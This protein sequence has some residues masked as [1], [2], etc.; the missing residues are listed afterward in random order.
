[1]ARAARNV[2]IV[3]VT[4]DSFSIEWTRPLAGVVTGYQVWAS[5]A[6]THNGYLDS[7]VSGFLAFHT[8]LRPFGSSTR[9]FID[10]SS[11]SITFSGCYNASNGGPHCIESW[12]LY[13]ISIVPAFLDGV[14]PLSSVVVTTSDDIPAQVTNLALVRLSCLLWGRFIILE[15][16]HVHKPHT[17]LAASIPLILHRGFCSGGRRSDGCASFVAVCFICVAC[18]SHVPRRIS[19]STFSCDLGLIG[20]ELTF[21][22][23]VTDLRAYTWLGSLLIVR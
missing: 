9:T 17:S 14:G 18:W 15:H 7:N 11:T 13:Q 21:S 12:T 4:H 19:S 10:D 8:E 5:F 22:G 1:M 20:G 23:T 16:K 6:E 3:A 2:S